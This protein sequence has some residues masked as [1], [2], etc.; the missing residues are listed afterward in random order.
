M[1]IFAS[2]LMMMPMCMRGMC[3]RRFRRGLGPDRSPNR[4][5]AG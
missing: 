1:T 2:G 4:R 3:M 5:I